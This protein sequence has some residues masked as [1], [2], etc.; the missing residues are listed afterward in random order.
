[1]MSEIGNKRHPLPRVTAASGQG[2]TIAV[3]VRAVA[4]APR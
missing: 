4:F 2:R 1:L 3:S